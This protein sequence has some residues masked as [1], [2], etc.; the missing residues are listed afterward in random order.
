MLLLDSDILI[1]ILR[2]H[3]PA[4]LWFGALAELPAVPGYVVMEL[5]QDADNKERVDKALQ[6]V[7]PLRVVWPTSQDCEKA[8]SIF[9]TYHLSH[10]LGLLDALI[11]STSVGLGAP[12]C[13]FNARHYRVVQ[14]VELV[15]PYER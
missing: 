5:I 4:V 13:T 10:G 1:D 14:Q 7:A 15:Q 9:T 8:L 3:E 2:G 6:L 11:G 12:L